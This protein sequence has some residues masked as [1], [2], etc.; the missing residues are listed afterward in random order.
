MLQRLTSRTFPRPGGL[1]AVGPSYLSKLGARSVRPAS[2]LLL[3]NLEGKLLSF[4]ALEPWRDIERLELDDESN[5]W[6]LTSNAEEGQDPA[7]YS[8][9]V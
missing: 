2:A 7:R 9:L 3:F 1:V 5:V 6:T 8:M 4:F